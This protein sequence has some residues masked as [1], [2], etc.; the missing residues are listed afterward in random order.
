M[1][2]DSDNVSLFQQLYKELICPLVH[3]VT[4]DHGIPD[5]SALDLTPIT[6]LVMKY[7]SH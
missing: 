7:L 4:T 6:H 2:N 1:A 5:D 3:I